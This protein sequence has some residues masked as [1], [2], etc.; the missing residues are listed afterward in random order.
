MKK[1][2]L[3]LFSM[4]FSLLFSV[5]ARAQEDT[6]YDAALAAIENGGTYLISTDV[7]GTAYYVTEAGKLTS[8]KG[9]AGI[10]TLTK[11]TGGAFKEYG[12]YIDSGKRF[13]NP[14]LTK[15][16]NVDVANL[17]NGVFATTTGNRADWE[18]QVLFLKEGKYAIRSCNTAHG[19]SSWADAGRTFWTWAVE[20]VPVPQYTY[21]ATYVWAFEAVTPIKVTYKLVESDGATEVKSTEKKQLANSELMVPADFTSIKA[22]DYDITGSI[23]NVDCTITVKRTFKVGVVHALKDLSNAKAY[24]IQCERGAFLTKDG[25]LASTAHKTL[26]DATAANFAIISDN[27]QYYLYSVADKKFVTNNGAL[28]DTLV[29]NVEDAILM[30]AKTDPFFL[31]YFKKG[32]TNNGLNTNGNDPYGYVINTWMNADA[33]NQYFMIE[34]GDFDATAALAALKDY[35]ITVADGIENGSVVA[36]K[37]K[38]KVGATIALT[39]TPTEG[40]ELDVLTVKAGDEVIA[41]SKKNTFVLPAADVTITATFKVQEWPKNITDLY[42]EN[43]DLSTKDAGWT[44]Y[45]DAYKYGDWQLGNDKEAAAIEFYAGW[46][47]LEHTNFKLSQ[48]IK[49][50]AGDYRIAVNAF[51]REGNDGNGT[52]ADKAWIFAGEKKQNVYAMQA[53]SDL[54]K[55]SGSNDMHKAMAAFKDGAF[56]NAFDFSLTEETEIEVGFEGCFD[57]IRQWCI[58]GPVEIWQ[59]SLE[60]YLGAYREKVDEVNGIIEANK[61]MGAAEKAALTESIVEESTFTLGSQVVAAI[62][63]MNTA[64]TNAKASIAGYEKLGTALTKGESYKA[65]SEDAEAKAAYDAVV[66]DVKTAY[67][68]ATIA[69]LAAATATVEA[70]LPTLAKTQ[71]LA[72]ADLTVFIVNPEINGA[73]GWTCDRP[74]G[75]N[76]P[77]LGGISFEYWAGNANPRTEAQFDYWQE[78]AGLPNGLYT[79]SAE[80]Y[81]S[82]NGEEG[83]EFAA[84]SGVYAAAGDA[85]VSSL[86]S[87][88]GTELKKYTTAQIAVLDGKIRIGVKNT[89]TPL[90]ARWFVA[91]NFGLT[92]V[93][94]FNAQ[95]L[96]YYAA[97]DAI[98]DGGSYCITTEVGEEKF[99][100]TADGKITTDIN[101]ACAFTLKSAEGVAYPIGFLVDAG[102]NRFSNPP[103]TSEDNL[104]CGHINTASGSR[105]DWDAQVFFLNNEGKYAV[106][107]TNAAGATSGWGWVGSSFW[108]VEKPED[109]TEYVAQYQWDPAY[110][111]NLEKNTLVDLT[112][113]LK[114]DGEVIATTTLKQ[115]VGF[116]PAAPQEFVQN[117]KLRG[118]YTL[119]PDVKEV[120]AETTEVNFTA[121]WEIF[122]FSESF[123]K[124]KWYNMTIRS[125]WQVSMC[126]TEPYTMKENATEDE[127]ASEEF[128]WAFAPVEGEPFQIVIYNKAA[129]AGQSLSVDGSNVVMR[130]GETKW[131]IFGNSDGFVMRPVGG[132][133]NDW[134]NQSGG[135]SATNPLSFWQSANGKTDNGS[136]FRVSEVQIPAIVLNA[137]SFVVGK[138]AVAEGTQTEFNWLEEGTKLQIKTGATNILVN[139]YTAKELAVKLT[140]MVSGDLPENIMNMGST[141]AHRVMG[142]TVEVDLGTK[143]F[144]IE[145]KPGYIYQ[146]IAVMAAELVVKETGATVATYDGEPVQLHWVGVKDA[147]GI[148]DIKALQGAEIYDLGGSKTQKIQKGKAYIIDGKTVIAK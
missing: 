57:A 89:V 138:E 68:E 29:N 43:A 142:E 100:L 25:Y 11:V 70:A 136:T 91:D 71:T 7:N 104:K 86:V 147:N 119:T 125:T 26:T 50:P 40:Y 41:V 65:H 113:N 87:E 45:S 9:D 4:M 144:P 23:G 101:A 133:D 76:G 8:A 16:D 128:Q 24:T 36:D 102:S 59:Y 32:G 33:G 58:L 12:F 44:Y 62:D 148:K 131:E 116:A 93:K 77:L 132:G 39:I 46:G 109:A 49:L 82:L 97:L 63:V 66:A 52:N 72:G 34:A 17:K 90:A 79:V 118:L 13:T 37:A 74:K 67:D 80:M 108:T 139:N 99:Y 134:V 47:S 55:W 95:D 20:E 92:L 83:A 54:S 31:Y 6:E 73:E 61:K 81:N 19:T 122:Q 78:I 69:D 5:T 143:D 48:K 141:T 121:T 146:N 110:I 94:P 120:T 53:M 51:Y 140:V 129:G 117:E 27:E 123:E 60:N 127:L 1:S 106:R 35:T 126:E 56:S 105:T 21:D 124:A 130:D 137:P 28:S 3:F 85:E 103:G 15:V 2:L 114:L 30:D 88:D 38:A 75:G 107:S 10:F 111:W 18:A 64:I 42:L 96:E 22:Y 135:G 98:E 115:P 84:T 14:P 145:L 112:Y